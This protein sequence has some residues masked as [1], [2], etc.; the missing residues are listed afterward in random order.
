M[1]ECNFKVSPYNGLQ[2]SEQTAG[3]YVVY[4]AENITL[5]HLLQPS[6][7]QHVANMLNPWD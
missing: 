3:D 2:R 6:T 1:T 5:E 4:V 7:W